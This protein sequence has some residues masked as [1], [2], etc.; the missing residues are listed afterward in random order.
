MTFAPTSALLSTRYGI[1]A[2]STSDAAAA[3]SLMLYGEWAEHETDLLSGA[4]ADGQHIIEVG[5]EHG[6]HTL[7]LARAVGDAG[8][9]HVIEPCRLPFQQLCANVALNQLG[10]VH[11]HHAWLGASEGTETVAGET[12]RSTTLDS[13]ALPALHLLKVNVPDA[14]ADLIEGASR[15][16]GEHRPLIYARLGGPA[17]AEREVDA[18]KAL[19]YRVW[20][21]TPLLFNP[22]NHAGSARNIFPGLVSCNLIAAHRESELEFEDLAEL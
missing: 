3:R 7:W 21:H 9:V 16:L 5:G 17:S 19:G 8:V 13:F 11:T 4:V 14:L 18:V 1:A 6:A 12:T 2:P 15:T 10:N 20:S 22:E